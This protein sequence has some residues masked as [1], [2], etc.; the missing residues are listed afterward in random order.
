[1]SAEG[2]MLTL[3]VLAGIAGLG[4]FWIGKSTKLTERKARIEDKS[5]EIADMKQQV[6]QLDERQE[7]IRLRADALKAAQDRGRQ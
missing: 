3:L 5:R 7:R 2:F 1:M 6:D 4:F